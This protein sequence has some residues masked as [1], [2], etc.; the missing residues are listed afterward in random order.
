MT[1]AE[2]ALDY[3]ADGAAVGLGSGHAAERF[4]HALADRVK[5]GLRVRGVPTSRDTEAL[6]RSSS[7]WKNCGSNS[8]AKDFISSAVTA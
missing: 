8:R 1:N 6:A 5:A 3:V 4:L 2:K 7:R